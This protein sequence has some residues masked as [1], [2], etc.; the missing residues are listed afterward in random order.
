MPPPLRF[1]VP[2]SVAVPYAL[3][4]GTWPERNAVLKVVAL[5][6]RELVGV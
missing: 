2:S 4:V 3:L 5:P 1:S 6:T